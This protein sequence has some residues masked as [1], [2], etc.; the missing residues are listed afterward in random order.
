M[1]KTFDFKLAGMRKPQNWIVC[2]TS[3][4]DNMI[5][6]QSDKSIGQFNAETGVGVLNTKGC[7]FPHLTEFMGAKPFTFPKEFVE[8]AKANGWTKGEKVG[9]IMVIG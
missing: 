9:G 1:S 6:V 5:T 2:P 7:Y 3:N 4:T 8:L